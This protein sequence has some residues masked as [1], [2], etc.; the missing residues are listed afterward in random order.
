MENDNHFAT[1]DLGLG[2]YLLASGLPFVG[3]RWQDHDRA[4]FIFRNRQDLETLSAEFFSGTGRVS[5][6]GYKSALD[7]L[8]RRL[9]RE[10]RG[11]L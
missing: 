6:L 4:E 8:K 1:T 3:L 10:R 2:A 11:E 9:W 7:Q 5:A